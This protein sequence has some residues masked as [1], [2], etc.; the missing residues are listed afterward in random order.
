MV[1]SLRTFWTWVYIIGLGTFAVVAV[2]IIP[3][4]FRDLL[5]LLR[6]LNEGD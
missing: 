4:G 5:H 2:T 3:W 1:E 6:E